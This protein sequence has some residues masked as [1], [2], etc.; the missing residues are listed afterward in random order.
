M[1]LPV[2]ELQSATIMLYRGDTTLQGLLTGAVSPTWNIFD[3][4]GVPTNQP[5][6][7]VVVQMITARL[8]TAFAMDYDAADVYIQASVF[9]QAGGFLTARGIAKQVDHLTQKA[10]LTL[11]G[12]FTNFGTLR[13]M[14]QEI[15]EKDGITQHVAMR[16]KAWCTG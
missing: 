5:F 1:G 11:T 12:G 10:Q 4:D 15:P 13:D 3:A 8:G 2:G 16:Y 6:P 9:T 14:Y 7:Y